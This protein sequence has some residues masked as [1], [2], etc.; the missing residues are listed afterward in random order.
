M[1]YHIS[2]RYAGSGGFDQAVADAR[3]ALADNDFQVISTIDASAM[4]KK[5][6]DADLAPY[7]ILGACNPGFMLR[8]IHEEP[9]SGLML[10]YNVAIRE[11]EGGEIQISA[12]DPF[13]AMHVID[14]P[15][16]DH[17]AQEA[18]AQMMRV[19]ERLGSSQED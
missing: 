13:A 16:L 18:R 8:D 4:V 11:V 6:L 1:T 3:A 10:P 17:V 19:I 5:A 15:G 9:L 2:T 7:V 12:I 14:N